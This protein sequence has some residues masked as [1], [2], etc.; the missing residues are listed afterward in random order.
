MGSRPGA[1]AVVV[2]GAGGRREGKVQAMAASNLTLVLRRERPSQVALMAGDDVKVRL[3]AGVKLSCRVQSAVIDGHVEL[4]DLQLLCRWV[5]PEPGEAKNRRAADRALVPPGTTVTLAS[6]VGTQLVSGLLLDVSIGGC[7]VEL[8]R[9][10]PGWFG[11]AETVMADFFLPSS[12]GR[13]TLMGQR[14][15]TRLT[16]PRTVQVGFAWLDIAHNDIGRSAI[17]ELVTARI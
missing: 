10:V 7:G 16:G 14:V 9:P 5:D 13:R 11:G 15:N 12:I 8:E 1:R 6:T 3:A 4:C 17:A 2:E